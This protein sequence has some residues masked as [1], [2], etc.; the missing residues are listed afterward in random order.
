MDIACIPA[1]GELPVDRAWT[2]SMVVKT[3]K[4]RKDVV[5]R[6]FRP[7]WDPAEEDAYDWSSLCGAP[8]PSKTADCPARERH[9][10]LESF[11]ADERDAVVNYLRTHYQDKVSALT[12]S[13]LTFPI[14]AG[15]AVLSDVTEGRD[16]GLV[17][18]ERLADWNLPF[19]VHGA[20]DLSQHRPIIEGFDQ[21]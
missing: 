15:Q 14:P 16:I 13:P 2:V 21:A 17:H 3:F 8:H 12:T 20:F 7:T 1:V 11:T 19:P 6:L 10:L 9:V 4:G 5:I 18:C